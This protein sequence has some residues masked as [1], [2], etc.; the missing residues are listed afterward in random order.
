MKNSLDTSLPL[1]MT[2]ADVVKRLNTTKQTVCVWIR[3]GK[4]PAVRMPNG[5]YRFDRAELEAWL[6]S[7]KTG[8][9]K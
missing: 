6:Q 9:G 2:T 5:D 3:A 8:G 7:R 1:L 4:L